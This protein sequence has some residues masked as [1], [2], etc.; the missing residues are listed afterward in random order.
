MNQSIGNLYNDILDTHSKEIFETIFK[1]SHV[2]IERITSSGQTTPKDRPYMQTHDEWVVV[3]QGQAKLWLETL[4]EV[5]L[6]SGDYLLI[7]KQVKHRVT[8][9]SKKPQ[10]L[11]LAI[12][13]GN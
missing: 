5:T 6:N 12:H 13:I 8:Y 4:G 10:T 9:T 7:P 11:W 3:L 1:S 2:Q